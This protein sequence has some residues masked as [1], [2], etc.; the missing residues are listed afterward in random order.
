M[1]TDPYRVVVW[2]PGGIGRATLK[3]LVGREDCEIV[4]VL[5]YS[6]DKDGK[7]V[8]ELIGTDPIGVSATTDPEAIYALDADVAIYTGMLPM[9]M[10]A[11]EDVVIRLLE[12]GKNVI[13][14]AGFHYAH[15]HGPEYVEK[16]ES[17]CRKGGVSLHGTGENPGFWFERLGLTL[18]GVTNRVER[19]WLH[20]YCDLATSGSTP[21]TL[22]MISFG[23]PADTASLP[24]PIANLWEHF[25]FV[26]I[27]NMGSIALF[28]KPLD[29]VDHEPTYHVADRD[30]VLST[31]EGHAL[32]WTIPEGHVHAVTHA[33]NGILDGE[34]RL[35]I[36]V[37]WFLRPENAPYEVTSEDSWVIEMEG[38]PVSVRCQVNALA[39]LS[40]NLERRPGDLT[41]STYYVTGATLIQAIPVVCAAEPGFVYPSIFTMSNTDLRRLE[42][43]RD[44]VRS[45]VGEGASA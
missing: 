17:A 19:L 30:I 39:S 45:S 23:V 26:E 3:Q 15:N 16:F 14:A 20:E 29:H 8:G 36:A 4:G 10:A 5:A 24:A 25:Y 42:G 7:D 21:E 9:D 43:R 12:S 38:H 6:P 44:I 32:D 37:N 27:L 40:D 35:G 1:R 28:G 13:H 33:F 31:A 2:G 11:M 22:G 18:T 41:S 34:S